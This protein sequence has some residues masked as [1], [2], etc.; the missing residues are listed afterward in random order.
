MWQLSNLSQ[1]LGVTI[2]NYFDNKY[3][4]VHTT[5]EG[6]VKSS[7]N[8]LT[9]QNSFLGIKQAD[10][11]RLSV[12]RGTIYSMGNFGS[13]VYDTATSIWNRFTEKGY[14][15]K[16]TLGNDSRVYDIKKGSS[17]TLY[18]ASEG[19]VWTSTNNGSTWTQHLAGLPQQTV[20]TT[21]CK[22][23]RLYIFGTG[24][25]DTIIAATAAGIYYSTNQA[26][27]FIQATGANNGNFNDMVF[28]QGKLFAGGN[29]IYSS[30]N[31]GITWT[32]VNNITSGLITQIAATNTKL[33]VIANQYAAFTNI[34]PDTG[35][36][37][38]L[39]NGI[40]YNSQFLTGYDSLVFIN[41][42]GSG[43]WKINENQINATGSNAANIHVTANGNLPF[44]PIVSPTLDTVFW[45]SDYLGYGDL[46]VFNNKLWLGTQ[47][48]STFYRNMSDFGYLNPTVAVS[49]RNENKIGFVYPNPANDNLTLELVNATDANAIINIYGAMGQRVF[50]Q[51]ANIKAGK[52]TIDISQLSSGMYHVQLIGANSKSLSQSFIKK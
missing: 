42:G 31:R 6:L 47:N 11:K 5:L 40:S 3:W 1:T 19:G 36:H 35:L 26:Q 25:N 28:A 2:T 14:D 48:L 51:Q 32:A 23:N 20:P 37:G 7:N 45:Y 13:F 41:N 9:W 34:G 39:Y 49:N 29:G 22:V 12:S 43:V 38:L 4:G 44:R 24:G 17:T 16:G 18:L 8:G 52:I 21:S 10:C 46:K 27:S 15:F 30:T 50:Q 33:W